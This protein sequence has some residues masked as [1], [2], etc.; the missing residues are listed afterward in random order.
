M[1]DLSLV[2]IESARLR[3]VPTSEAYADEI[4]AEFT[5]QITTYMFPRPADVIEETL[6]FLRQA[7]EELATGASLNVA[8][9]AQPSSEFLGHGGLHNLSSRTPELGIW[10]KLPAHGNGYGREAVTA[11]SA[12]ALSNLDFDYLV[13]PVDRRNLSSRRI[14]ESLGGLIRREYS[15]V[16]AS[17]A[18]LDIVEYQIEPAALRQRLPA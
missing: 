18:T 8:I 11:L 17:G 1:P 6:A 5:S 3:L 4:F 2:T 14:P 9:L 13:Y 7:Q 15:K 16:N 12:W 10:I